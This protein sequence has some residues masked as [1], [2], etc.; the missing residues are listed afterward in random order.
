[1][2]HELFH[3]RFIF[4]LKMNFFENFSEIMNISIETIRH[5]KKNCEKNLLNGGAVFF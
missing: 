5:V 3:V 1:M 4:M 2:R